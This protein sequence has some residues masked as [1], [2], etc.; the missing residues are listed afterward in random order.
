MVAAMTDCDPPHGLGVSLRGKPGTVHDVGGDL[1]PLGVAQRPVRR[2]RAHGAVPYRLLA[3]DLAVA[4]QQGVQPAGQAGYVPA[5]GAAA[6]GFQAGWLLRTADQV[7]QAMRVVSPGL[8]E[9]AQ[10]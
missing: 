6:L 10:Q 8:V 5:A 4:G 7:G 1:R 9:L 3:A 2:V